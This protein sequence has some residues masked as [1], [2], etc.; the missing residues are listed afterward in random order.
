MGPW[1]WMRRILRGFAG[2]SREVQRRRSAERSAVAAVTT[3]DDSAADRGAG[4]SWEGQFWDSPDPRRTWAQLWIRYRDGLGRVTERDITVRCIDASDRAGLI[5]AHCRLRDDTRSFRINRILGARDAS[6]T[7][8]PDVYAY[9]FDR[10]SVLTAYF[11]R[12]DEV[13]EL[14][15]RIS[16]AHIDAMRVLFYVARADGAMRA[17]EREILVRWIA[18]N[19]PGEITEE[20]VGGLLKELGLPTEYAFAQSVARLGGE[21]DSLRQGVLFAA[22][23]MVST[24]KTT[25]DAEAAA[26][27]V[28]RKS[29]GL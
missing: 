4:D 12:S 25:S 17:A 9:L 20:S 7:P 16:E 23:A 1:V 29:W 15:S 10:A 2:A 27:A 14:L 5:L 22:Q 8:V 18:G 13:S 3:P 6:G 26:I 21:I 11:G 19:L 24:Q 28:M